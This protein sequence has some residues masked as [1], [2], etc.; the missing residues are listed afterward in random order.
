ME[1]DEVSKKAIYAQFPEIHFLVQSGSRC[2]P[3]R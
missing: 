2:I 3:T 1:V